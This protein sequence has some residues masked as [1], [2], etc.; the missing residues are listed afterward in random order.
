MAMSEKTK[1]AQRDGQRKL[2]AD[3]EA[4]AKRNVGI[5]A[6]RKGGATFVEC[7]RQ[8]GVSRQRS[9]QI[10]AGFGVGVKAERR[11]AK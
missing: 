6:A 5:V 10:C 1:Q 9:A 11:D 8:F 7:A 2:R 4:M 3:P